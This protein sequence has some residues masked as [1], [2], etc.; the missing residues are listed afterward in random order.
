MIRSKDKTEFVNSTLF[1]RNQ[2]VQVMSDIWE[3]TMV[4]H[5]ITEN[6]GVTTHTLGDGWYANYA[7]VDVNEEAFQRHWN[8]LF[9]KKRTEL[10]LEAESSSKYPAVKGR[11]VKVV[12]GRT[13]K[14]VVGKVFSVI[15]SSYSSGYRNSIEPKLGI[16][17][18]DIK[19][20]VIKNGRTYEQY[21]FVQWIWARNC[22]VIDPEIPDMNKIEFVAGEYADAKLQ[23]L[24]NE[25][26]QYWMANG[27]KVW[28]LT[29]KAA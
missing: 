20:P 18:N 14:G 11:R 9:Q 26:S 6:G 23:D 4:A 28:D 10:L 19:I 29:P 25:V 16:A 21:A 7:E 15:E 27:K 24:R 2:S 1:V 3:W 13:A 22:E 12:R 5:S 8:F 17:L